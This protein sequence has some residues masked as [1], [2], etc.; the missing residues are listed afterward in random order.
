MVPLLRLKIKYEI[1]LQKI[2]VLECRMIFFIQN[3]LFFKKKQRE[4]LDSNVF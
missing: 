1:L 2:F 3:E 4:R